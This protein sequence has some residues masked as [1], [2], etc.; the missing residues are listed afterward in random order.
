MFGK[1]VWSLSLFN[2]QKIGILRKSFKIFGE[3]EILKNCFNAF[4][5]PCFEYCAPV[6]SSATN[7]HLNLLDKNLRAI[8]FLIPDLS[9]NLWH[10]RAVSSLCI[11]HK[12]FHN[13]NH[14][15]HRELPALYAPRR[16][17]RGALSVNSRAFAPFRFNTNQYARSF[18]LSTTELWNELPNSVVESVDLQKFKLGANAFLMGRVL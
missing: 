4:I 13:E 14:P 10:R 16:V 12:I 6:W 3:Q 18:I 7:S 15:L 9:I 1:H 5:L 2:E 17:T 11:L 8:K